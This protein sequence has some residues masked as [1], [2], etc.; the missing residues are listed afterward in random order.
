MHQRV[1]KTV[2]FLAYMARMFFS[3]ENYDYCWKKDVAV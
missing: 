3:E 2:V 1:G